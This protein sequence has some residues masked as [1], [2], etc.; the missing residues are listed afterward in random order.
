MSTALKVPIVAAHAL[1]PTLER[2]D[3]V[4][5]FG[6]PKYIFIITHYSKLGFWLFFSATTLLFERVSTARVSTR[7]RRR[8]ADTFIFKRL[9]LRPGMVIV[10]EANTVRVRRMR[11]TEDQKERAPV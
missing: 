9:P 2:L 3:F 11:R 1:P 8:L 4:T 5:L 10:G 6:T 7:A